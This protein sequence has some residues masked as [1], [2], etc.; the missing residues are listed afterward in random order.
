[1]SRLLLTNE[2]NK[3]GRA[4]RKPIL[5]IFFLKTKFN[6]KEKIFFTFPSF[7]FFPKKS[8]FL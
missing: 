2:K 5:I 7:S 4:F 6:F 8:C 3:I 1:M